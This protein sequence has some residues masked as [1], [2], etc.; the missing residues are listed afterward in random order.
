VTLL[1]SDTELEAIV[2]RISAAI[3]SPPDHDG[4]CTNPWSIASTPVDDLNAVDLSAWLPFVEELL[5]QRHAEQRL[6]PHGGTTG[7]TPET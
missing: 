4:A 3:C 1:A 2:G 5:Q 7:L 6:F